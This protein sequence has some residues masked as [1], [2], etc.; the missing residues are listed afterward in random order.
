MLRRWTLGWLRGASGGVKALG[1]GSTKSEQELRQELSEAFAQA[2][3]DLEAAQESANS[4]FFQEELDTARSSTQEAHN[5]Y[6]SLLAAVGSER[7][8][9]IRSEMDK[10]MRQ[11]D[12][13][14]EQVE[15]LASE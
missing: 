1:A 11:L 7:A 4:T 14:R 15:S 6:S 5:A 9:D 8:A 3:E 2:R 12:L 10:N 13:E